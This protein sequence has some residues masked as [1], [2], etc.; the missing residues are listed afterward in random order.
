MQEGT[1]SWPLTDAL[2]KSN[3]VIS[4]LR[5][6]K[7]ELEAQAEQKNKEIENLQSKI[8]AISASTDNLQ[9]ALNCEKEA[10][11]QALKLANIEKEGREEA[12]STISNLQTELAEVK[13]KYST[14]YQ[15]REVSKG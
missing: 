5:S 8:K 11:D 1:G 12:Q 4:E 14:L 6:D 15:Q 7:E 13:E 9:A 10:K 2:T 3:E